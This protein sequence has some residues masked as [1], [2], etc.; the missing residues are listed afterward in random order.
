[1]EHVTRA[2]PL[3]GMVS[4][5][6]ANTWYSLQAH[7]IWQIYFRRWEI[8]EWVTWLWPRP[9]RGQLVICG[10]V[11]LVAKPCTKF[12]VCRFSRS[13]HISWGVKF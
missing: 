12:K 5:L 13:K 2:T 10:L 8:L 1:M 7:K 6:K 4:H 9:L 11:L 3:L